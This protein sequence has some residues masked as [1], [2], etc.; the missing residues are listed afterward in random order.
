MAKLSRRN[1]IIGLGALVGGTGA[2]AASGA[3]S[4]VEA[5]RTVDMQTTGDSTAL[6]ALTA[7]GTGAAVDEG[8]ST[9]T[10]TR[11]DLN[12]NALTVFDPAF[13]VA[14]NGNNDIGFY[15]TD[16]TN[17]GDG[18]AIDFT[19]GNGN[20]IVGSGNSVDITSGSNQ[21]VAIEIDLRSN[22]IGDIPAEI[23]LVADESQY[24]GA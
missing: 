19:D 4:T 15:V 8:G 6:L 14:N 18:L 2:M 20:S 12:E 21:D 5:D 22:A 11:T 3:F 9:I 16:V 17:V 10:L 23:T 1:T 7:A 24:S 13:N